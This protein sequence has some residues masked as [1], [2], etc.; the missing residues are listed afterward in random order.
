MNKIDEYIE[1]KTFP[2]KEISHSLRKIIL[3]AF[4]EISEEFRYGVQ[5]Y[6]NKFYIAASETY[7]DL[8]FMTRCLTKEELSLF[9]GTKTA[10]RY[11]RIKSQNE[12]D[13]EYIKDL[14]KK[15]MEKICSI[16]YYFELTNKQ[17]HLLYIHT[18]ASISTTQSG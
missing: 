18:V 3:E 14:L 13:D 5:F 10:I 4:P 6:G 17:A 8:G 15:V 16:V 1:N 2:Q 7:V 12:V 11:I 9:Q